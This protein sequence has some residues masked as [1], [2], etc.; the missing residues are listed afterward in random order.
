M[1]LSTNS[2]TLRT[3]D[4]KQ[5]TLAAYLEEIREGSKFRDITHIERALSSPHR[6]PSAISRR[7]R[8]GRRR[9]RLIRD[10]LIPAIIKQRRVALIC[11][12]KRCNWRHGYRNP[13]LSVN[14]NCRGPVS[15]VQRKIL[16]HYS[17]PIHR[18]SRTCRPLL[19]H[20]A[21]RQRCARYECWTHRGIALFLSHSC[22]RL[23]PT[24]T[25][26][27]SCLGRSVFF[28]RNKARRVGQEPYD[29]LPTA[30]RRSDMQRGRYLW[31]KFSELF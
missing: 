6:N 31:L 8:N 12:F 5:T 15:T 29:E 9:Y 14:D 17:I 28:Y 27:R 23:V 13:L 3:Q 2:L 16:V 22:W 7:P 10:K 24:F 25:C 21:R 20:R 4:S 26:C 18:H 11:L 30:P 19:L 1:K